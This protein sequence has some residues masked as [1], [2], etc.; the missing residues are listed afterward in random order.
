[1]IIYFCITKSLF[2]LN[3]R[4]NSRYLINDLIND[5]KTSIWVPF[6]LARGI[7]KIANHWKNFR[8]S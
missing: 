5:L 2:N 8:V 3:R 1:M 4:F 7:P 6:R